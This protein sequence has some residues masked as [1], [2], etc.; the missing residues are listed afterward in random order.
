MKWR[1]ETGVEGVL[2][3][4]RYIARILDTWGEERFELIGL[5]TVFIFVEGD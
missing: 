5:E 1:L 2:E 4:C 3:C